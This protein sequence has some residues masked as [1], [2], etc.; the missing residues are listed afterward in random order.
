MLVWPWGPLEGGNA[1]GGVA[2][3]CGFNG[4]PCGDVGLAFMC[5]G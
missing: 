5:W 4:S 3:T 1:S 2:V